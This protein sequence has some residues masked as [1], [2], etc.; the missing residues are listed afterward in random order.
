M[1]DD[2][3][4]QKHS[5]PWKRNAPMWAAALTAVG[6]VIL[7]YAL[8]RPYV[9]NQVEER[10]TDTGC[11]MNE[12][13]LAQIFE[14][15]F[16]TKETRKG[17]G[18]GLATAYG[19]VKQNNGFIN[20]CSE[21]AQGTTFKIYLSRHLGKAGHPEPKGSLEPDARGCETVLLVEDEPALL[22]LS[23]AMLE[24]LG[25]QVLAMGSPREAIAFADERSGSVDLLMTDVVMPE[26]N[27]RD[28]A[29]Q[30]Q[31]SYPDMKRLFM[32][33]YTPDTIAHHGVLG[34]DVH[35]L[36]KPFAKK[37]LA[38]KLREALGTGE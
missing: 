3:G 26:M 4:E 11:G 36:Q 21:Q 6:L 30:L 25:Y 29:I 34:E 20:V 31:R 12:E 22:R 10:I 5:S 35:F 8:S 27:G 32:S 19:I 14:P 18:L 7:L 33:G 9:V 17:T 24:G 13:T 38:A 37:A 28:L 1:T 15:F 2:D 23:K 16:T